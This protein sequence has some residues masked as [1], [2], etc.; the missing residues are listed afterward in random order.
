MLPVR[1][2]DVDLAVSR[3]SR[4]ERQMARA[5]NGGSV[6]ALRAQASRTRVEVFLDDRFGRGAAAAW[7]CVRRAECGRG[8]RLHGA[9]R[10][11]T[12]IPAGHTGGSA[13]RLGGP[14]YHATARSRLTACLH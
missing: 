1:D 4:D 14:N 10:L 13:A 8:L 9:G 5:A 12:R 11:W 3:V 7:S 6:S 2:E